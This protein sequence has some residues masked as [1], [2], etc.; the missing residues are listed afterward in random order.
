MWTRL[1]RILNC[2][3]FS[4]N[5]GKCK[6]GFI[7]WCTAAVWLIYTRRKRI[8]FKIHLHWNKGN[9]KT[10][11]IS[12]SFWEH[13]LCYLHRIVATILKIAFCA[14]FCSVWT[15]RYNKINDIVINY[16]NTNVQLFVRCN[17]DFSLKSFYIERQQTLKGL[18]THDV[19]I[20]VCV[21][22]TASLTLH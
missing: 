11:S 6:L 16:Y 15:C 1:K 7:H 20:C 4:D 18:F 17:T 2:T 22:V 10:T 14:H 5:D 19:C 3:K 13:C 21:N 8:F 12:D 9:F